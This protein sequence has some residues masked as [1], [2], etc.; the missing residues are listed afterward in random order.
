MVTVTLQTFGP[1]IDTQDEFALRFCV[2]L[3]LHPIH[4]KVIVL[5]SDNLPTISQG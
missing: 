4:R 1:M 2:T 3:L 5:S